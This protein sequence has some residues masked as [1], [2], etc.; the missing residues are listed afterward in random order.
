MLVGVIRR[1]QGHRTI[2]KLLGTSHTI[3]DTTLNSERWLVGSLPFV[4]ACPFVMLVKLSEGILAIL[5]QSMVP[6][7]ELT[8]LFR[9]ILYFNGT[10]TLRSLIV[11]HHLVAFKISVC[12]LFLFRVSL[13]SH[14]SI[15]IRTMPFLNLNALC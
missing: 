13:F 4:R 8:D 2:G 3:S 14:S 7:P 12:K 5:T 15:V 11:I 6:H 1:I 9:L 10:G